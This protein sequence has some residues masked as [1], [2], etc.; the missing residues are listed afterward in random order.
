[1]YAW[2]DGWMGGWLRGVSI[3]G[4]KRG[5]PKMDGLWREIL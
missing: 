3:K 4:N 5:I 1:M 2:M